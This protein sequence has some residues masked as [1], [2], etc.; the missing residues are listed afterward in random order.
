[1]STLRP[2]S[3]HNV[4]PDERKEGRVFQLNFKKLFARLS[5][6]SEPGRN[7]GRDAFHEIWVL[8]GCPIN[9]LQIATDITRN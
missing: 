8:T 7:L 4:L 1:M 6:D 2:F 5:M 9:L 3:R